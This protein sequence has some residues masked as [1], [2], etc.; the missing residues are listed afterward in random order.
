MYCPSSQ[1]SQAGDLSDDEEVASVVTLTDDPVAVVD[2]VAADVGQV[3]PEFDDHR[4]TLWL[5]R[6]PYRGFARATSLCTL[7]SILDI[8]AVWARMSS[9]YKMI[10]MRRRVAAYKCVDEESPMV[11]KRLLWFWR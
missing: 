1:A 6:R 11:W 2:P 8:P 4:R 5:D 7:L 9:R 3:L 10:W